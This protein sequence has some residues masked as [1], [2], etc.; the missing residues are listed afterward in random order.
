MRR[1]IILLM[2][3]GLVYTFYSNNGRG[4]GQAKQLRM[5]DGRIKMGFGFHPIA[6]IL[7]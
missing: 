2:A 6:L 5:I 7:T 1:T 4:S 3:L